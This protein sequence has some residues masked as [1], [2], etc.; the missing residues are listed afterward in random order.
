M[1][2]S[3]SFVCDQWWSAKDLG[4]LSA[5]LQE[6]PVRQDDFAHADS[7]GVVKETHDLWR[8]FCYWAAVFLVG[9]WVRLGRELL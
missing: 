1:D 8:R 5:C 6:T 7:Q 3:V 2:I 9:E 4:H